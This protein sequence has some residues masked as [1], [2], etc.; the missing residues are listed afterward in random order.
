MGVV[1]FILNL[2]GKIGLKYIFSKFYSISCFQISRWMN[3]IYLFFLQYLQYSYMNIFVWP[4]QP[5]F[6]LPCYLSWGLSNHSPTISFPSLIYGSVPLNRHQWLWKLSSGLDIFSHFLLNEVPGS[7]YIF[8]S[9][10]S[11]ASSRE[12]VI[13]SQPWNEACE[14]CGLNHNVA[15][16]IGMI[17]SFFSYSYHEFTYLL[18]SF[19]LRLS[20]VTVVL[21]NF[22]NIEFLFVFT[23]TA[24]II[25]LLLIMIHMLYLQ[26]AN[27]GLWAKSNSHLIFFFIWV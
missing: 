17:W 2:V 15:I 8:P 3:S 19:F 9:M 18:V 5:S 10:I 14:E 23:L 16:D 11:L 1:I 24:T 4:W 13:S 6:I 25:F 27:Y 20:I 26:L 12:R 7:V 22:F 21:V